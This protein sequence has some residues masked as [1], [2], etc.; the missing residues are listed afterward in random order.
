[1]ID[2]ER[3]KPELLCVPRRWGGPCHEQTARKWY[4]LGRV[5][6]Q[7]GALIYLE[8][9]WIGGRLFTTKQAYQRFVAALNAEAS[10]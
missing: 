4:K 6:R 5:N 1:M 3:E 7:T 8:A 9:V 10:D 2:L